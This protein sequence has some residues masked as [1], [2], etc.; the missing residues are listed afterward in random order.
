LYHDFGFG[1]EDDAAGGALFW[2]AGCGVAVSGAAVF[3]EEAAA[4]WDEAA[5]CDSL[6]L[7]LLQPTASSRKMHSSGIKK[8]FV[9][10]VVSDSR[11]YL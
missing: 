9:R 10:M 1:A 7:L 5:S 6:D 2:A 4:G 8:T 11:R 3:G